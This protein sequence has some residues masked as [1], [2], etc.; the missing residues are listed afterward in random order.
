[1]TPGEYK[2]QG[3]GLTI[4]YGIHPT[5]FGDCLVGL[6]ERGI[7]ALRFVSDDAADAAIAE[8]KE[9]WAL[10]AFVQDD[11]RTA[12]PLQ[13]IFAVTAPDEPFRLL[14]K[15]TN[16]QVQVW[17]ALLN[18]PS[19]SVV[20]YADVA[21]QLGNPAATR[22]VASAIAKNP[23]GYLIPCHRVISKTGKMHQYRW[24]SA[25]KK[26]IVG[27]EAAQIGIGD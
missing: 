16:F 21:K 26:A 4:W 7:C 19:G 13:K 17:R 22:A 14:L 10:A 1:M 8:L 11:E 6:T 27:W 25:R 24:G 2:R 20:S 18:I 9:E 23:V 5:P 12:V 15:G 3:A